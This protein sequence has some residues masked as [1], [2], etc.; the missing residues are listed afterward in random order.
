MVTKLQWRLW[1]T[2][3]FEPNGP[4]KSWHEF[5]KKSSLFGEYFLLSWLLLNHWRTEFY[6][7]CLSQSSRIMTKASQV[8][9]VVK[10]SPANAGDIR[11]TNLIPGSG[12][13]PGGRHG[14]PLQY[15]CLENPMD[16]GAWRATVHGDTK[17]QTW[18]KQLSIQNGEGNGTP[19]RYSCLENPMDGGAWWAAVHGIAR[20]RT[21]L[22]D[23]TFTFHFNALEKEMATQSSVL[24]WRIPGTEEAGGLLSLGLH[25]VGHDWSNLAAAAA[26]LRIMTM[27]ISQVLY[28]TCTR[29]ITHGKNAP[30]Y[31]Q[32]MVY[33]DSGIVFSL[34]SWIQHG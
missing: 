21:W 6:S 3:E 7:K 9:L 1:G 18:L 29:F 27:A 34:S 19:L 8:T 24:A 13:A 25:R 33:A 2:P 11:G 20:S 17:S 4:E 23:F 10:N 30:L 12:R 5:F 22:R 26:A 28:L 31:K 14:N 32:N 16:R 15:S